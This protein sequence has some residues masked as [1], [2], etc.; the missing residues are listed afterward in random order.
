MGINTQT[1]APWNPASD[2]CRSSSP[3]RRRYNAYGAVGANTTV[4]NY[5]E[6]VQVVAT[7]SWPR[8]RSA[9]RRR[10]FLLG[11]GS[12]PGCTLACSVQPRAA[13]SLCLIACTRLN[14]QG[15]VGDGTT[16]AR[17]A[18]VAVARANAT[19]TDISPAER[20]TCALMSSTR[21][22]WCWGTGAPFIERAYTPAAVWAAGQ[23][24][25]WADQ[26]SSG[27][28]HV[29]MLATGAVVAS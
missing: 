27:Y 3:S 29:C 16:T 22:V 19:W 18:P 11:V 24:P 17:R 14:D 7:G 15:Q 13:H 10:S 5:Y 25:L 4:G 20:F 8:V 26:I 21:A 6:P 12:R 9:R 23:F 2:P 1:N 28:D